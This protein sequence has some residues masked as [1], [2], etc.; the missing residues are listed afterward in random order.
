LFVV[1]VKK[2]GKGF[3][4]KSMLRIIDGYTYNGVEYEKHSLNLIGR[5]RYYSKHVDGYVIIA[6]NINNYKKN[7]D[8]YRGVNLLSLYDDRSFNIDT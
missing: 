7:A 4:T 3:D 6:G 5:S 1:E 2:T 8:L